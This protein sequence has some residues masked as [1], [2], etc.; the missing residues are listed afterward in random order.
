[1]NGTFRIGPWLVEPT[2]NRISHDGLS[3]HL[4]PKV[5]QVLVCLAEESGRVLSKQ[6]LIEK[7]WP[8]TFVTDDVLKR[9]ISELRD[10]FEDDAR[11]PQFI[12]T[13]HKHG[14]R[15][16]ASVVDVA[17]GGTGADRTSP[18]TTPDLKPNQTT[19]TKWWLAGVALVT[20]LV[21]LVY[22]TLL[23][24]KKGFHGNSLATGERTSLKVTR[25]TH[26]GMVAPGQV[27][28]SPDG[29]LLFY[30]H[31]EN[32]RNSIRMRQVN[33]DS[34]VTV[35]PPTENPIF[36]LSVTPQGD[37]LYFVEGIDNARLGY[38][39]L[40]LLP[41]VGGSPRPIARGV[42]SPAAVSPDGLKIAFLRVRQQPGTTW[43]VVTAN[44]DGTEEVTAHSRVS[45]QFYA[46]GCRLSWSPDGK[47]IAVPADDMSAEIGELVAVDVASKTERALTAYHWP[48]LGIAD[49]MWL[50][51]G[52][53]LIVQATQRGE[54]W[55]IWQ[56][57]LPSGVVT[58]LTSDATDH[59]KVSLPADGK[60][61]VTTQNSGGTTIWVSDY[62]EPN[63]ARQV[64]FSPKAMDVVP[65][66][67]P[68][69]L[70]W[71]G[72]DK[73]VF[74]SLQSGNP[75]LW[76]L[77]LASGER[78]RLTDYPGQDISP[79]SSP[80]GKYI[81]YSS[82]KSGQA[83]IWRME[84]DG[85]NPQQITYTKAA[86][87]EACVSPDGTSVAF[88]S[89]EN[90][91]IRP[92]RIP[93]RGG[94]IETLLDVDAGATAF[95][96]DGKRIMIGNVLSG[97]PGPQLMET[98][99]MD[100]QSGARLQTVEGEHWSFT[101]DGSGLIFIGKYNGVDNLMVRPL[102]KNATYP[103][104]K[105]RE[106]GVQAF[107]ISADGKRLAVVRAKDDSDAVVIT[108]FR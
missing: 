104:T 23:W 91:R 102:A 70:S 78:R 41:A 5:M 64:T 44:A 61:I 12:E 33:S 57:H 73:L 92:V 58:R 96:L 6:K 16:I 80:D 86:A 43:E 76:L 79:A 15:L 51:D 9:A 84:A 95:S 106:E 101:P 45:P 32:G 27:E 3:R 55:H 29:R 68:R 31:V 17:P 62:R 24:T 14:Y 81:Y 67:T 8:E 11:Y 66:G 94:K 53:G 89:Y 98:V 69:G 59:F 65:S 2:L 47:S 26:S 10:A 56:V 54:N 52:S 28:I 74:S 99:I 77:D 63:R 21:V 97:E 46:I 88:T 83:N 90:G 1:M 35:L 60:S 100:A 48:Q 25:L 40:K 75:D 107:A 93:A 103:L 4:E 108:D 71:V 20:L 13:I 30:V 49:T 19:G 7:V 85:T 22:V 72:N 38:G 34:E 87:Y 82:A 42:F 18:S 39:D 105:F 36:G 37:Y 50:P